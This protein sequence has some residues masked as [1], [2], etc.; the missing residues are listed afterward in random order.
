MTLKAI[1]VV[2]T[3]DKADNDIYKI[4]IHLG[5]VK[6]LICRYATY[7]LHP[8]VYY[9]C[10]IDSNFD[11]E[12][13]L[14]DEFIDERLI[15]CNNKKSEW[16][17]LPLCKIVKCI[18]FLTENANKDTIVDS[19]TGVNNYIGN[20]T[21]NTKVKINKIMSDN[22][23]DRNKRFK[24]LCKYCKNIKLDC[25]NE[26]I[27]RL[28]LIKN[29]LDI[30]K[31]TLSF[32]DLKKLNISFTNEEYVKIIHD[33]ANN[34]KYFKNEQENRKLFFQSKGKLLFYNEQTRMTYLIIIQSLLDKYNINLR[35]YCRV[36]SGSTQRWTYC[37]TVSD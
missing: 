30:I 14:K 16:I 34:S 22:E 26:D 20:N 9:F 33:I 3:Q 19:T 1:Y 13:A 8:V 2:S 17:N 18:N 25:D 4:G 5:T 21:D 7:V 31:N 24:L 37:L 27:L 28:K 23:A 29:M 12:S 35:K 32:V 11:I 15:N 10:Y 36:G 6:K